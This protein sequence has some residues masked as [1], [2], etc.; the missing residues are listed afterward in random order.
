MSWPAVRPWLGTAARVLLGVVWIWASLAKLSDPLHFVE[1]VR[2]YDATWEWLS[3][4]IGYGLPVLEFSLGVVLLLGVAVR[5]AAAVSAALFFV[6]LIGLIQAAARG[7]QLTCGCFGGGGATDGPTSFTLDILRDIGLLIVAVYLVVWSQSRISIDE[8]L[9]RH[10]HV[11]VPSAKR[12]RTPEGRRRYESALASAQ[13]AARSR[14]LYV[15]GLVAAVVVLVAVI[16]IGVQ[17]NRAQIKGVVNGTYAT[18]TNGVIFGKKAAATVDV[19]EDFGCPVCL[20]LEQATHQRLESEV[21]A[22]LAQ[23]RYHPISILDDRSPNHYSTRAANAAICVSET[24]DDNFVAYHDLL[25]GTYKG[26]QVQP[27]EGSPGFT[28]A[29]LITLAQSLKLSSSEGSALVTCVQRQTYKPLIVSMTDK[30]SQHGVSG[31]PTV[32]VNGSKLS[33]PAGDPSQ[34]FNAIAA[35]DKNGPAPQPSQTP[36]PTS[37]SASA[38]SSSSAT[39]SP[40]PSATPS[41]SPSPSLSP[42]RSPSHTKSKSSNRSASAAPGGGAGATSPG[43][44]GAP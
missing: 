21:R 7:L 37:S 31:T 5:I 18:A 9:S 2:A 20:Q 24:G 10:D 17:A 32:F 12:M 39:P 29:Q 8:F 30:A 41:P 4:A 14:S 44:S 26:K 38:T 13:S 40:T 42:S 35:A 22:N 43:N 28:N 16:G 23:V 15:N 34:L 3:K 25:Y 27:P 6:F 1:T 36:T 11:P 33:N 19:Y